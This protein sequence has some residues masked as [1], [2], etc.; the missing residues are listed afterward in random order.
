MQLVI[1]FHVIVPHVDL[2]NQIRVICEVMEHGCPV[3]D[4]IAL[5]ERAS[6]LNELW[7]LA[8]DIDVL[9]KEKVHSTLRIVEATSSLNS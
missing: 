9:P 3:N 2:L 7:L 5:V 6:L 4:K 8:K 1:L